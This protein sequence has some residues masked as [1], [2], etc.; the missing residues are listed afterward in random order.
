[1]ATQYVR[2]G[3]LQKPN[4]LQGE[5]KIELEYGLEEDYNRYHH[6]F[7]LI[8]G[9]YVPYFIEYRKEYNGEII[10]LEDIDSPEQAAKFSLKG[11]YLREHEIL[12][13]KYHTDKEK[14]GLEGY[15]I[16]DGD[17]PIAQI[18]EVREYPQQLIA[19]LLLDGQ[20]RLIPLVDAWINNI[21]ATSRKLYMQLPEGILEV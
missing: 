5:M 12:S 8:N 9:D 17:K 2:V 4:G 19:V 11:V 13:R 10:K 18:E 1:M 21:D 15:M 14:E 7:I 3:V 6:M 20:E 16:Y